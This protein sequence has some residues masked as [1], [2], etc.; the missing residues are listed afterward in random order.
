MTKLKLKKMSI[1]L[2]TIFFAVILILGIV[3]LAY[4]PGK[5]EP[6]LDKS[7]NSII[8]S[9]SEK[10][11]IDVNGT[12]QGMFIKSKDDKHPVLLILHG[13]MPEYFLSRNYPTE[14]EDYF[15]VVW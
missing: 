14:L 15:T 4:S 2:L 3:L 1:I 8:G 6:Y 7:G 12:K 13:G 5:S 10:T 11:F 9:I